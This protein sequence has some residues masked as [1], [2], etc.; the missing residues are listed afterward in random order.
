MTNANEP[1][2]VTQRTLAR[3]AHLRAALKFALDNG[4]GPTAS[5][6]IIGSLATVVEDA[7]DAKAVQ[8]VQDAMMALMHGTPREDR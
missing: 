3:Q 4:E 2:T 1:S 5:G 6:A 8:M 7:T